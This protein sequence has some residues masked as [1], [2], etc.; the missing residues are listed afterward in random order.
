MSSETITRNDLANILDKI[1]AIDGTDMTSAEIDSFIASLNYSGINAVDYI[2]E[3]GANYRKWNSGIAEC[4][5]NTTQNV[6]LNNAYGSLYQGTWRW[7]FPIEFSGSVPTVVCSHFKWGTGASWGTV[8]DVYSTHA[9]LRGI[10][11]TSRASGST[12]IRA[13]AIGRWK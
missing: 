6:A 11:A 12:A 13:Y 7:D 3:Q 5:V 4:W 9:D 8:S 2:V 1:V 10:D